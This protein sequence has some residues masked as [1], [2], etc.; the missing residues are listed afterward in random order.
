MGTK[1]W[2]GWSMAS[3]L[4]M[5]CNEWKPAEGYDNAVFSETGESIAAVFQTY[6]E[7]NKVTH[8][9]QKNHK[10]QVILVAENNEKTVL[11]PLLDGDVRD[12]F[13]QET[14]GYL[15]LGRDSE[16]VEMADGSDQATVS[17]DRIELDGTLTSLGS[18]TGVV[19]LSCDDGQ[20]STMVTPPLRVIPSPDGTILA[21]IQAETTC[22]SRN[23]TLTFLDAQS[24]AV[25]QGPIALPEGSSSPVPLGFS[26]WTVAE[27]AWTENGEFALAY[28]GDSPEIDHLNALLYTVG[29]SEPESVV[30]H[31]NCFSAPTASH[32]TRDDGTDVEIH[33]DT[34]ALSFS[35]NLNNVWFGCN[36]L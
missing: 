9:A 12:L 34:G 11:T 21:K 10:S 29:E 28:W 17:Y 35:A 6:E 30:L 13:Y 31:F 19:M 7:K 27:M 33:P 32:Y 18:K 8:T 22:T 24:L 20:S 15:I 23:Q 16:S 1:T 4:A 36:A 26:I 3:L 5:G 2:I 14:E 25:I